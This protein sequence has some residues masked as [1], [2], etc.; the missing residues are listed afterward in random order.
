MADTAGPSTT[1]YEVP[2]DDNDDDEGNVVYNPDQE[3]PFSIWDGLPPHTRGCDHPT[4]LARWTGPP[5]GI[6]RACAPMTPY[7]YQTVVDKIKAQLGYT[8]DRKLTD[9]PEYRIDDIGVAVKMAYAE[10]VRDMLQRR[11]NNVNLNVTQCMFLR[12]HIGWAR[13]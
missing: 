2:S 10:K 12:Q 8:P 4:C 5:N 11:R 1:V 3:N 9:I 6:S 7:V 13:N